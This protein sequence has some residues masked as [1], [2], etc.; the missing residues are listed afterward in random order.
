MVINVMTLKVFYGVNF[1]LGSG[2]KEKHFAGIRK[3]LPIFINV[4]CRENKIKEPVILGKG[5]LTEQCHQTLSKPVASLNF[6]ASVL[7]ISKTR[8]SHLHDSH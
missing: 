3:K 2:F 1:E 4:P 6:R 8:I 5:N 7:F